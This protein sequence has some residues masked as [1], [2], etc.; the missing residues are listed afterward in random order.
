MKNNVFPSVWLQD[1]TYF[2]LE[3]WENLIYSFILCYAFRYE[4][5]KN[6]TS[7]NSLES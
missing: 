4:F 5:W 1:A 3:L 6:S 2:I 7:K